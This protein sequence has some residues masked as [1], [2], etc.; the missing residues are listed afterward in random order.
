MIDLTNLEMKFYQAVGLVVL[1]FSCTICGVMLL[2]AMT[3]DEPGFTQNYMSLVAS[4]AHMAVLSSMLLVLGEIY[5]IL[6]TNSRE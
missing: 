3:T 4:S 6:K 5:D 1:M 2:L